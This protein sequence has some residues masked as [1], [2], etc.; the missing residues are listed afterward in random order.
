MATSSQYGSFVPTN[1]IWDIQQ[2]QSV[3]VTTPQFKEL[4]VRLYQNINIIALV[5]NTKDTG[6]Y[7]LSETVNSQLFF[8]NP[9]YNSS[10]PTTPALRQVLR[11]VINFGA[12]PNTGSTSVAHG[13]NITSGYTFTRIYGAASDTT[14]EEYIPIPYAS[15][16][17]TTTVEISV[18]STDVVITTAS[19]RSSFTT[20]YVILEYIMT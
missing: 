12:L 3:D 17:A 20:T 7:P 15:A 14:N 4:L 5:L 13:I 9:N 10:T 16:S 1:Y 8:S 2:L 6:F 18:D 19:N 11:K